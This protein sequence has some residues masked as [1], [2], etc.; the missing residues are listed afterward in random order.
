VLPP[1]PGPGVGDAQASHAVR[2]R[3][4]DLDSDSPK[5]ACGVF[6]VFAPGKPVAH[7]TYLGLYALQH[8]GQESAGM[9]VSDGRSVT[10]V[11]DMG[12]VATV[13]DDRTL[14]AL[15]G[16]LAIGHTRYSTTGSSTWRNAQPVYR[17][18]DQF[19]FALGHN[20]NLVNTAELAVEAGMLAGT[21]TSDSDLVAEL[22]EHELVRGGHAASLTDAVIAVVP[23]LR[24]AFSFVLLDQ[25]HLM[26]VRDPN[27]LRPLCLGRLDGGWV[28]AS[29]TPAL[30]VVGAQFVRELDPGELVVVDGD[31]VRS[32]RPFDPDRVDPKLCL[33]EFVY[34]SRPDSQLYGQSVHHARVRMGEQLAEQAPVPADLVMGVPE[35]GLPAAEGYARRSGIPYGQGLVKNRYIG[36]TF[37]APTQELRTLGV[38][39]KLNPLRDNIEG[40]RLVVVDDSI[41]RGTT[42]RAMVAMLRES[43]AAEVHLRV[44]S[45]PYRW[46]CFYGMDTGARHELLAASLTVDEIRKYL[47]V[48]TLAYL[49]LDRLVEATGA[50]GAGFCDAC[51]T[52]TYPIPVPVEL[53]KAVLE[54]EGAR[55]SVPRAGSPLLAEGEGRLPTEQLRI[56]AEAKS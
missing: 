42:T 56:D 45:P 6:G 48:D 5:E 31:D 18:V 4:V 37:I 41:V 2:P 13:F 28:F 38:R 32:F 1:T 14:A 19:E 3:D 24:G 47:G 9:A 44:S 21:V 55:P 39:M 23:K 29:E 8:R 51:L 52:G 53:T 7:L 16:H 46:P 11:K 34:F 35:S 54:H 49:T 12:L 25:Q 17:T 33:F 22:I 50:V 30:D 40:K 26:A 43:G 27:G 15:P 10:V 20:G 36:R